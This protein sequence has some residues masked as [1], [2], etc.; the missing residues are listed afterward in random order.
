MDVNSGYVI[1][2][3]WKSHLRTVLWKWLIENK[4]KTCGQQIA[5]WL[6][7]HVFDQLNLCSTVDMAKY[8]NS[9]IRGNDCWMFNMSGNKMQKLNSLLW[10]SFDIMFSVDL[11]INISA[12]F[13]ADIQTCIYVLWKSCVQLMHNSIPHK[14][15]N[16]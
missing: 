1:N 14:K 9:C 10:L 12:E 13:M 3:K 8:V 15:N 5:S 11:D 6:I 4:Y 2:I 7:S 16:S